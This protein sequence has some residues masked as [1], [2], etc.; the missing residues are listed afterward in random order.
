MEEISCYDSYPRWIILISSLVSIAT[1][2]AGAFIVYMADL[3][4]LILYLLLILG[5]EVRLLGGHCVNCWYYGKWCAF[6]RGALS[7][8]LFKR[9]RP[10]RFLKKAGFRDILPD[11]LI[12]LLPLA[13]GIAALIRDFSWL[14]L[15]MMVLLALL[16]SAGNAFVR[17]SLA[18]RY[19]RQRRLGC[20]A[21]QLFAGKP[22]DASARH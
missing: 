7:G 16:A 8:L 1:Y 12:V 9:G 21:E 18:C 3:I 6:G 5:L 14:V 11:L 15:S 13:A 10:E 2:A 4:F 20:P 22:A 19:C 17:G